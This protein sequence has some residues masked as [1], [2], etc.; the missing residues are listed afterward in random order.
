MKALVFDGALRM[1]NGYPVP[2][3]KNGEALIKVIL[4]GICNTDIEITRGYQSFRGVLGHEF[5]GTVERVNDA[6]SQWIGKRV[7]GEINCGCN[8]CE[9]CR[10]GLSRHCTS[11][12][13][14]GISGKDGAFAEYV[15]L[16]VENLHEVPDHVP[17][18][19]AIFAEPLAAAFEVP[20]QIQ[21]KPTATILVLG[22]G[23][24][25]ILCAMVLNLSQAHVT[26]AGKHPKKL[27]VAREQGVSVTP[28]DSLDR[29]DLY[30]IVVEATGSPEGLKDALT[31]VKPR[32]TVILKS[33]VAEGKEMNLTSVVIN[34]ISVVGSRCGP[35]GPALRAIAGRIIHVRPLIS[36]IYG[37]DE[38]L[39]AFEK[40]QEKD[41]LKVLIRFEG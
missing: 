4:A 19:E 41:S 23:K 25:G 1:V 34:E 28:A 10:A 16:P 31:H 12:T 2:E 20:D 3:P 6:K 26:L 40:A 18:E 5:V 38:A 27:A 11:R 39:K 21:I 37:P 35:F 22:D 9:V 17:D 13:T 15:T 8:A 24:L 30:D 14:L 36:G 29:R 7:V 32:G 33:T